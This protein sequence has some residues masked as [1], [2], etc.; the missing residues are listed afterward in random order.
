[1]LKC[2]KECELGTTEDVEE[3]I[4]IIQE[5]V[6]PTTRILGVVQ[7]PRIDNENLSIKQKC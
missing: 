5:H 6:I 4:A 3:L 7:N 1:M 2:V